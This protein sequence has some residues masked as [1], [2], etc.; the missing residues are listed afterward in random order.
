MPE[1]TAVNRVD[2]PGV[3]GRRDVQDPC[4]LQDRTFHLGD[5]VPRDIADTADGQRDRRGAGAVREPARPCER[6]VFHVRLVDLSELAVAPAGVIAA[7]GRPRRVERLEQQRRST[8]SCALSTEAAAERTT[9]IMKALMKVLV[10]R[11]GM[12]SRC[13]YPRRCRR[14]AGPY[15][16]AEGL[17]TRPS[18]L[19]PLFESCGGDRRPSTR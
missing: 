11:R 3:V 5:A 1:F 8:P 6:E 2:R 19:C 13:G 7:V 17:A 10:T 15:A 16:V 14:E 4:H 18:R 12:R 9:L